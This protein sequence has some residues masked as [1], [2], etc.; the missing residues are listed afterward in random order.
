MSHQFFG[1]GEGA[2]AEYLC[3]CAAIDVHLVVG[4]SIDLDVKI[5]GREG[6]GNRAGGEHYFAEYVQGIGMAA[7]GDGAHIPS[8]KTFGIEIC[9]AYVQASAGGVFR[10]DGL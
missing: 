8:D 9:G 3:H 7:G 4:L 5:D 1:N 6:T 10:G 2:V